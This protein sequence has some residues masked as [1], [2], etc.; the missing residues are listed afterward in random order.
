MAIFTPA[1]VRSIAPTGDITG[2]ILI[3]I[4]AFG[5]ALFISLLISFFITGHDQN[6]PV[7]FATIA[8]H[9]LPFVADH[10]PVYDWSQALEI[11]YYVCGIS[12][13]VIGIFSGVLI[14]LADRPEPIRHVSGRQKIAGTE[15]IS[16][17]KKQQVVE[18][19]WGGA[20]LPL[21]QTPA[22]DLLSISLDRE[23][24]HLL[25]VGG[26]GAGKTTLIRPLID[27]ARERG[28]RCLIFDN[29]SD[30]TSTA[31]RV[32][33]IILIAPWDARGAAWDIAADVQNR[34]DAEAFSDSLITGNDKDPMWSNAA[35]AVLTAMI[36][37]AQR[38]APGEWSFNFL[39]DILAAGDAEIQAT[40][41]TFTPEFSVLVADL[42]SRTTT[43]ILINLISFLRPVFTLADAWGR[44]KTQGKFS[45]RRW[46]HEQGHEASKST[47]VIQGN[48]AHSALQQAIT[49]CIFSAITRE[50]TSP[51]VTDAAP[52]DRSIALFLDEFKQLGKLNDFGVLVEVGRSKGVRLSVGIQDISQ[53]REVY[54]NDVT[55]TWLS[56]FGTM[57]VGRLSGADT[58]EW[59]SKFYG[60]RKILRYQP[61]YSNDGTAAPSRTDQWVEDDIPVVRQE[62]FTSGLGPDADGVTVFVT[63][64]DDFVYELEGRHLTATEK[65]Q[66]RP[67]TM[68]ARWTDAD[69][70]S[71]ANVAMAQ[72]TGEADA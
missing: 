45:M 24:K 1:S 40:V 39:A 23:T 6:L 29:K 7:A 10:F 56:S 42:E 58:S 38:Q 31:V 57:I 28:D 22:G 3:G 18:Q 25:F 68:P 62:E 53:L 27:A 26:I 11:S 19:K 61:S 16:T 70:P 67:A 51:R 33:N 66:K 43:S 36:V 60:K 41:T 9:G 52:G 32:K 13:I 8:N 4:V 30:Y 20:G 55:T 14:Y 21:V 65:K 48:G 69:W 64:G 44:C 63:T 37:R 47:V 34:A 71:A 50:I 15:A 17:W 49:Q 46:I 54:G 12:S 35:R 2:S 59:V 5:V 72:T